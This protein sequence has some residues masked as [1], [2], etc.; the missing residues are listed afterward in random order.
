MNLDINNLEFIKRPSHRK[1]HL[2]YHI[3][4]VTKNH[5]KCLEYIKEKVFDAFR[6]TE[7]KS[8]I[9]IMKMNIDKDHIHLLV[10]FPPEYSI[11]QTVSRLKQMSTN[12]LY[13]E[14]NDYLKQYY[15][16]KKRVLWT[17]GYF[18]YTIGNVNE[19]I[20]SKYIENQGK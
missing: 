3:I 6:Y 15:C 20:V 11:E 8:H 5:R 10:S 12:Y 9:K 18:A 2:R 17:H 4:F 13:R 19:S 14:C 1:V 7:S 16:K